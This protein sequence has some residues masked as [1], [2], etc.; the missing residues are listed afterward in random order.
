M[1]LKIV[2]NN[3]INMEADAIVNTA[4]Y[5]PIVGSGVDST[6][7]EAAGFRQLLDE[8]QKIGEIPYGEVAVTPA[9]NLKAKY[10]LHAV[11]PFWRGGGN[12]EIEL[13]RSCYENIM[14]LAL[15]FNLIVKVWQFLYWQRAITLILRAY[16][17]EWQRRS[18]LA[19]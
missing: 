7:Y 16:H 6:I 10:I 13:L 3:I 19:I 2:R 5:L 12:G 18:L 15:Q 4:N 14:R 1:P 11:T 9:F 17:L 8:R